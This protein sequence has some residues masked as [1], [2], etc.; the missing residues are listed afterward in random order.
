MPD[1]SSSGDAGRRGVAAQ[2]IVREHLLRA[3][4]PLILIL[5]LTAVRIGAGGF[6]TRGTNILLAGGI[7]AA[8]AMFVYP[9]PTLSTAYG[10]RPARPWVVAATALGIVPLLY[11]AWVIAIGGAWGAFRAASIGEAVIGIL[12]LLAGFAY[13]RAFTRLA[14]VGRAIEVAEESSPEESS[15]EGSPPG[16]AEARPSADSPSAG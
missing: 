1:L 11:G 12:L 6:S 3:T 9:L 13:L 2:E 15:P 7:A 10:R 8:V 5:I 16:R 14:L 4:I